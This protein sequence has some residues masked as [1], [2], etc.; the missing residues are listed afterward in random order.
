MSFSLIHR[1]HTFVHN[2]IL[3]RPKVTVW[4]KLPFLTNT[5]IGT[6]GR[7]IIPGFKPGFISR[8]AS[9][10]YK[11]L[12]VFKKESPYIPACFIVS[13]KAFNVSDMSNRTLIRTRLSTYHVNQH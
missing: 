13:Y 9:V 7:N 4:S 6:T 5:Y 1:S 11:L 12:S 2:K 8:I 10:L 3:F